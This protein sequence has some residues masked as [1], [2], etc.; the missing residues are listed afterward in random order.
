MGEL[1]TPSCRVQGESSR[2]LRLLVDLTVWRVLLSLGAPFR[3]FLALYFFVG[4]SFWALIAELQRGIL[5]S[6]GW[7]S[8][9]P[10]LPVLRHLGQSFLHTRRWHFGAG[11]FPSAHV[12]RLYPIMVYPSS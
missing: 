9:P 3:R 2:S 12:L 6:V 7:L 4:R 5:S 1:S 11:K 8:A 10:S